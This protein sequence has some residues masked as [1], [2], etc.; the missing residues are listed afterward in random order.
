MCPSG[1]YDEESDNDESSYW[2]AQTHQVQFIVFLDRAFRTSG[3]IVDEQELF[4]NLFF[5][6]SI[7]LRSKR[8]SEPEML[9]GRWAGE[10]FF[11]IKA[12]MIRLW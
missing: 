7:S 9:S 6:W 10:I 5:R 12:R 4:R 3:D 2:Q 8:Y 1:D 11:I